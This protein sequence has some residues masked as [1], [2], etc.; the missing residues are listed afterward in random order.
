MFADLHCHPSNRMFNSLRQSKND[1]FK[2]LP[3]TS[4]P[5]KHTIWYQLPDDVKKKREQIE[6]GFTGDMAA[7]PQ[8]DIRSLTDSD[9]RIVFA[10]I[11]PLEKGFV[12]GNARKGIAAESFT[13]LTARMLAK[14]GKKW[15]A[16]ILKPFTKILDPLVNI[17]I[18][19]P[20][21]ARDL[22]QKLMM[23]F[24]TDRI[25]FIQGKSYDYFKEA[26]CEYAFYKY[27]DNRQP[28]GEAHVN[29]Y[30]LARDN[31]HL[32]QIIQQTPDIA[33]IL[34]LEGMHMLTQQTNEDNKLEYVAWEK[35]KERIDAI[36][37]WNVFFVTYSHHYSNELAGHAKSLPQLMQEI[38]DQVPFCNSGISEHRPD[39]MR[40]IR[41]LLSLDENNVRD[42][43][44]GR[45]V[46]IDVKH[47][48]V[49]ARK[50]YYAMV[51]AYNKNNPQDKIPIIASHVAYA[52]RKSLDELIA[53]LNGENDFSFKDSFYQWGI[54]MSDEDV[55][56]IVESGGIIGLSFD[57]R[58]VG[59]DL[60][61]RPATPKGW[62]WYLANNIFAFVRAC[63]D[64]NL[65]Q[66]YRIWDCIGLGTD[67]DGFID[68]VNPFGSAE[69]FGYCM[70]LL[71]DYFKELGEPTK[72][73]LGLLENPYTPEQV[74]EK[75]AWKNA[76]EF[77]VRNFK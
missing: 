14:G 75:I 8:C 20:G 72:R 70:T 62:T 15:L 58:I 71:L 49:K 66:P 30:Q 42:N 19:N 41:R 73:Y 27:G 10:A 63:V 47:M 3:F 69:R 16:P 13:A 53:A 17:L 7:F 44:L 4:P 12:M 37:S 32:Q 38:T 5:F 77:A 34:T 1:P 50:E 11:Y 21:S 52:N 59:I 33:I 40:A 45:R 64:G 22:L 31:Q 51:T 28:P 29:Q 61:T 68:P 2:N 60:A 39:G 24:S 26:E 55:K 74:V 67:F 35:L 54:N 48:A 9:T 23:R 76:Y 18:N 65:N 25:N 36:K 57:Q 46:L 6:K 56:V 43:S